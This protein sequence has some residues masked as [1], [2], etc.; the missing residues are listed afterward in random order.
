MTIKQ[1]HRKI[2]AAQKKFAAIAM[3]CELEIVAAAE[4]D[5]KSAPTFK[6]LAY[7]GGLLMLEYW[8]YPVVV[9]LAGMDVPSQTLPARM[10]HDPLKGVGHTTKITKTKNKLTAEGVIS[11]ITEWARD[12][13]ESSKNGFPWQVSMGARPVEVVFA[14]EKQKVK[15]NG[16][17]FEGPVYLVSKSVLGELS[18]VDLGADTHSSAAIAAQNENTHQLQETDKMKI[19]ELRLL[20]QKFTGRLTKEQLDQ[21]ILA[22]AENDIITAEAFTAKLEELA[23]K[24]AAPPAAAVQAAAR[25]DPAAGS[26]DT[27]AITKAA[28]EA[29]ALRQKTIRAEAAG[30]GIAPD[31]IEKMATDTSVTIDAARAQMLTEIRAKFNNKIGSAPAIHIAQDGQNTAKVL[32]A[33]ALISGGF[34]EKKVVEQY[35]AETVESAHR[36]YHGRMGLQQ[37]LMEAAIATGW[38]GR[39]FRGNEREILQAAFSTADISGILSNIANKYMLAAFMA[40]EQTWRLLAKI[41]PVNDFKTVTGYRLTGDLTFEKVGPGGEL[42]HGTAGEETFTNKADTYGKLFDIS[43]TDLINDDLGALSAMP[44]LIG[45]GGAIK[46]CIVFWTE[47]QSN[48]G[49]FYSAVAHL[50]LTGSATLAIDTLTAAAL[51]FMDQVDS[52]KDP[53]AVEPK[54]LVVGSSNKTLAERLFKDTNIIAGTS[55]AKQ[56]SGNPHQGRYT[57][58]V[59]AYVEKTK[60]G[61]VLG[62][63]Y[64]AADPLDL[65]LIEVV[66]L[67]G[68]ETPIVESADADF[69]TLGIKMRGYYDF[70]AAKQDYRAA[71]KCTVAAL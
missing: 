27:A 31:K 66:F 23:V 6:L 34:G 8:D 49:S 41:R 33:A 48:T 36:Q 18:F 3:P 56:T 32:E 69:N 57:P 58:A 37:L 63:W 7:T 55:T 38:S 47:F 13:I 42:K 35:G 11:R 24:H 62:D 10:Q 44:A 43:R 51:K 1:I 19:A 4:G 59:S 16:Q 17:T 40:V 46:L 14:G 60:Y 9:E 61:G 29:E 28:T 50:N 70:G 52:N 71:Q 26:V 39:Y 30:L 64:L 68:N 21:E 2:E 12:V 5:A 65:P 20:A 54:L 25:Q 67:N 53:I 22:A 15:A 45:R